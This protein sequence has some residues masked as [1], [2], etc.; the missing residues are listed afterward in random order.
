MRGI[1]SITVRRWL[2]ASLAISLTM[3]AA[4][5]LAD[6]A[7]QLASSRSPT[8][9]LY[10]GHGVGVA[11]TAGASVPCGEVIITTDF[12]HWRVIT[13]PLPPA[14]PGSAGTCLY[15][16]SD[17][18]FTSPRDGW[19]LARNGGSTQT[20]L[21]HTVNGGRSWTSEPAGDTGSNAGRETVSFVNNSLGWRQQFGLGSNGNY[22]LQRT[23]NAGVTWTTRTRDPIGWCPFTTDAFSSAERGFASA[24]L[25]DGAEYSHMWRTL[26][27]GR[28][29]TTLT[30]ARPPALARSA[31]GLYGLPLFSGSDGVVPVD[32]AL[33]A[34]Q[35]IYFYRTTNGGATWR[36]ETGSNLPIDIRGALRINPLD[37]QST[38]DGDNS[39]LGRVALVS[40]AD[41]STWWILQP[42]PAGST[43]RVLVSDSGAIV[44]T[45]HVADLPATTGAPQLGALNSEDALVTV[46]LPYGSETTYETSN[47]GVTWIT[48]TPANASP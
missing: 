6:A 16:W 48:I 36:L 39:V 3:G 43:T 7:Q 20:L 41:L 21:Q 42:G 12:Q 4:A 46:P 45:F 2:G 5:P 19:L 38:C 37:P 1:G 30:L 22:E 10:V 13:P 47:G 28:H 18:Y 17:A 31:L 34:R 29:W 33:G 15:T 25:G 26:D 27:G 8:Y 24:P 40:L 9:L 14:V 11:D 35:A 32:Y 23:R 44:S